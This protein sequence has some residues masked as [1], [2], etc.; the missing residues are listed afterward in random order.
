MSTK[1]DDLVS[2]EASPVGRDETHTEAGYQFETVTVVIDDAEVQ[3]QATVTAN[4]K[5]VW[6]EDVR[7]KGKIH[8]NYWMFLEGKDRREP[9]L[10]F[11]DAD[12]VDLPTDRPSRFYSI[13][14]CMS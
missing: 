6:G 3:I 4:G 8:S 10:N 11:G 5:H 12:H 7:E 13:P 9:D 14:P 2:R 1:A